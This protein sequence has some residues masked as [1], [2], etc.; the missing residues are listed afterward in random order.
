[1]P[2]IHGCARSG[3]VGGKFLSLV[4]RD[5]RLLAQWAQH[6]THRLWE[7]RVSGISQ[8]PL[9]HR[10]ALLAVVREDVRAAGS[11]GG[12]WGDTSVPLPFRV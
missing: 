10:E 11:R 6:V 8:R 4:V 3:D 1:M 7:G 12:G 2:V 9:W 5:T